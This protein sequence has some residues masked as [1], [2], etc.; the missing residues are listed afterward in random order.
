MPLA[1]FNVPFDHPD[2]IFEPKLDGFRALAYIENGECR[3]V[4]RNRNAFKSFP[5]LSMA[6]ACAVASEAIID[7]EIV[8]VGR[9]GKPRF[10]DLMRRRGPQHFYAF[11]LLWLNGRDL[12]SLPLVE[13][14]RMLRNL[15]PPQPSPILY[16]DYIEGQGTELFQAVCAE[17]VEGIVAKLAHGPYTPDAT[18]WVK[19]K[20]RAYTQAAGRHEFF[21]RR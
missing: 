9:D 16:V 14:K 11:D 20:N 1:R 2:W 7:G 12:R 3:L 8:H 6:I 4:S 19:I 5:D 18:T 15:V 10:F 21:D 17:D 13:R